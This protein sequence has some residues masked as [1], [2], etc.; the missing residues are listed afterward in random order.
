MEL[1][2]EKFEEM[3]MAQQNMTLFL[4]IQD[5]SKRLEMLENIKNDGGVSIG[6]APK[7]VQDFV[8]EQKKGVVKNG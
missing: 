5:V 7:F 6:G 3:S 1:N 8:N 2:E 4:M